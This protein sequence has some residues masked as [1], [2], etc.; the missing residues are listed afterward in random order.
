MQIDTYLQNRAYRWIMDNDDTERHN[1]HNMNFINARLLTT[2][3]IIILYI[4]LPSSA[5]IMNCCRYLLYG[6]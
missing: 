2:I 6:L 5:F 3:L 1:R 4:I